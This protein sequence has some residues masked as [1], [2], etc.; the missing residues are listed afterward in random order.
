MHKK[1]KDILLNRIRKGEKFIVP[2]LTFGY[3]SINEF[4]QILLKVAEHVELIEIGMPFSDPLADGPIIQNASSI[5]LSNGVSLHKLLETLS[6]IKNKHNAKLILM[7]YLNPCLRYVMPKLFKEMNE[8]GLIAAIFPD[9]PYGEGNSL[10]LDA[11]NYNIDIIYLIS[12]TTPLNRAKVI[13][14]VSQ[15]F[16]YAVTVKGITGI[17][18]EL[19]PE[20]PAW[21]SNLKKLST[22]PIF[23][24]FGISSP[25]QIANIQNYANGFIIGSAIINLIKENKSNEVIDFILKMKAIT[26]NKEVKQNGC[27]P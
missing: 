1:L 9:L 26:S 2:Y 27:S 15:P 14:N 17:R 3:P 19:P 23:T 8:A 13:M 7:S 16:V 21:L 18:K 20:L 4:I 24:G 22:T 6:H 10:L 12:P 5:A 11:A 25:H